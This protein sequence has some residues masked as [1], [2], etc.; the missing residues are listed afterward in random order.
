MGK[1]RTKA[2]SCLKS[3]SSFGGSL[4][5]KSQAAQR[6]LGV[7]EEWPPFLKGR[8]GA[9]KLGCV[10]KGDSVV[11]L[12]NMNNFPSLFFAPNRFGHPNSEQ[13]GS[14]TRSERFS[15]GSCA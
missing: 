15:L 9:R 11:L 14:S 10:P 13:N 5:H 3:A 4:K 2:D 8:N 12:G 1:C 7:C 6:Q